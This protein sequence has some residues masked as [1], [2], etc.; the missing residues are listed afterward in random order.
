MSHVGIY[1][2]ISFSIG[3]IFANLILNSLPAWVEQQGVLRKFQDGFRKSYFT[4]NDFTLINSVKIKLGCKLP[5]VYK[6]FADFLVAFD[7]IS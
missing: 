5:K 7:R 3:K 4:V 2:E 1:R 6:I